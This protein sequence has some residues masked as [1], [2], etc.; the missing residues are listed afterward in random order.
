MLAWTLLLVASVSL[1]ISAGA[2]SQQA[3]LRYTDEYLNFIFENSRKKSV[4]VPQ[5]RSS[6]SSVFRRDLLLHKLA[7]DDTTGLLTEPPPQ[8]DT[9]LSNIDSDFTLDTENLEFEHNLNGFLRKTHAEPALLKNRES[10]VIRSSPTLKNTQK[11]L[12]SSSLYFIN[13]KEYEYI[14]RKSDD[15][16]LKEKDRNINDGVKNISSTEKTGATV[17]SHISP[18]YRVPERLLKDSNYDNKSSNDTQIFFSTDAIEVSTE[19]NTPSLQPIDDSLTTRTI[20]DNQISEYATNDTEDTSELL[21]STTDI[22]ESTNT[23]EESSSTPNLTDESSNTLISTYSASMAE[24]TPSTSNTQTSQY[25]EF[26]INYGGDVIQGPKL[27]Y[28]TETVSEFLSR[29]QKLTQVK[30]ITEMPENSTTQDEVNWIENWFGGMFDKIAPEDSESPSVSEGPI[31]M[32]SVTLPEGSTSAESLDIS[33]FTS[34]ASESMLASTTNEAH[35]HLSEAISNVTSD[36]SEATVATTNNEAVQHFRGGSVSNVTVD[37][38]EGTST[39]S[40]NAT[41]IQFQGTANSTR[42]IGPSTELTVDKDSY[43]ATARKLQTPAT[44]F[45]NEGEADLEAVTIKRLGAGQVTLLAVF[46]VAGGALLGGIALKVW[47]Y[48]KRLARPPVLLNVQPKR[49]F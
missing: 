34:D 8:S 43:N 29:P 11:E 37:A 31:T 42:S 49:L 25:T 16:D 24:N 15:L 9:E 45:A 46:A 6:A 17:T 30:N 36:A 26:V 35:L 5:L 28:T 44:L 23:T 4:I 39:I 41:T 20:Y 33:N 19:S 22:S 21:N 12:D 40:T 13:K 10:E 38:I 47:L 27:N 14:G 2:P 3:S 7:N 32:E 1:S 18:N 48:R